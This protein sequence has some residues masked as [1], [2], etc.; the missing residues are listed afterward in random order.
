[1]ASVTLRLPE[2]GWGIYCCLEIF[3]T[4][5]EEVLLWFVDRGN[6]YLRSEERAAKL[7]DK[8]RELGID[9]DSIG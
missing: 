9:P 1:M 6:R 7:A 3:E 8:L 4:M 2:V 5:D